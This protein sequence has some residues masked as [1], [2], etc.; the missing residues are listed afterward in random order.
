MSATGEFSAL[1]SLIR[2]AEGHANKQLEDPAFADSV[3]SLAGMKSYRSLRAA[4]VAVEAADI[5]R[6]ADNYPHLV[7]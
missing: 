1:L 4:F 5:V 3:D 2:R 7:F 6:Y